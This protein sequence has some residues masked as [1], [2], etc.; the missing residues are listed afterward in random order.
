MPRTI[1][2][3][4]ANANRL[5][6][7]VLASPSRLTM[8]DEVRPPAIAP[9]PCTDTTTPTQLAGLSNASTMANTADSM[10]PTTSERDPD[11]R[12]SCAAG[13]GRGRCAGCRRAPRR[14]KCVSSRIGLRPRGRSSMRDGDRGDHEGGRVDDR[15]AAAAE[16]RE[17]ARPRSAADQAQRLL[18][19]GQRS[20]GVDQQLVGQHLLQQSVQCRRAAR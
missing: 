18:A 7:I 8:I 13:R 5:A 1:A 2:S 14:A 16:R 3:P 11:G 6:Q 12:A 17:Q 9:T 20:V 4:T 10:K 19:G 15:D